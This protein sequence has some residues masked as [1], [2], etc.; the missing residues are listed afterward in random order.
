MDAAP[1]AGP[2][3]TKA[4]NEIGDRQSVQN[5]ISQGYIGHGQD[6]PWAAEFNAIPGVTVL[7]S[8]QNGAQQRLDCAVYTFVFLPEVSCPTQFFKCHI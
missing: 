7:G 8:V 3:L 2:D 5:Q 6:P 4:W 1:R